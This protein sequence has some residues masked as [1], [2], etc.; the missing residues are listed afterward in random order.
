MMAR[1]AICN[2][3]SA[4]LSIRHVTTSSHQAKGSFRTGI[5]SLR[6]EC[7]PATWPVRGLGEQ[8]LDQEAGSCPGL[9]FQVGHVV[10]DGRDCF[11]RS[12]SLKNLPPKGVNRSS[13]STCFLC[14][15]QSEI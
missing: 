13:L 15:L 10:S 12:G 4:I 9:G 6:S 8:A 1:L 14:N 11:G 7:R 2:L 5:L 3:Q